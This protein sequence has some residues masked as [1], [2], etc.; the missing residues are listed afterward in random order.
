LAIYDLV[1]I[2]GCT[3][4]SRLQNSFPPRQRRRRFSIPGVRLRVI[5]HF[6]NGGEKT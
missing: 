3:D 4:I 6:H 1:K 2:F 5:L